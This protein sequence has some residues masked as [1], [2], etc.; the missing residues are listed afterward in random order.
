MPDKRN[1]PPSNPSLKLLGVFAGDWNTEI[2]WSA[3]THALAGGPATVRG[4]AQF[5]W[6]E[7][8]HF[9]VQRLGGQGGPPQ[10]RWVFGRDDASG[11][12]SALYSDARGVSRVYRMAL[13]GGVWKIWRDTPG[14]RQRFEATVKGDAAIEGR[15]DKSTDGATW[16]H[17]FDIAFARTSKEADDA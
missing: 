11:E 3:A 8:G 7:D 2:R 13:E 9:L 15:W 16:E 17:D 5:Y 1:P 4:T 10:A 12:Y 6:I 14:F